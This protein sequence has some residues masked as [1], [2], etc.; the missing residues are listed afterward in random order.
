MAVLKSQEF[1]AI[2]FPADTPV[3][4][5]PQGAA[6]AVTVPALHS[7]LST[8]DVQFSGPVMIMKDS[9]YQLSGFVC[10]HILTLA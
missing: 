3:V 1:L 10:D 2:Q 9:Q 6:L 4:I 7:F 8:L 5:D